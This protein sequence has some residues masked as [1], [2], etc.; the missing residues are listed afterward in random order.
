MVLPFAG[1]ALLNVLV[2]IARPPHWRT[3]H[4]AAYF[5][6]FGAPWAW[7]LDRGW[8][9]SLDSRWLQ[10][11]MGYLVILWIP[12]LLYSGCL[13]LLL[14]VLGTRAGRERG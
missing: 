4:V 13:W 11:L 14:R 10:T 7:L 3:E 2:C 8:F 1:A 6:L 9:G 5:F 12:A